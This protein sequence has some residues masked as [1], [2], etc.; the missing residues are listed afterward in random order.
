M[1][2]LIID[3]LIEVFYTKVAFLTVS[4]E[5]ANFRQSGYFSSVGGVKKME[6]RNFAK[7]QKGGYFLRFSKSFGKIG[8]N[9]KITVTSPRKLNFFQAFKKFRNFFFQKAENSSSIS[10]V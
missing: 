10:K 8:K 3:K 5:V 6:W 7:P 4:P 2:L 9:S 1:Y